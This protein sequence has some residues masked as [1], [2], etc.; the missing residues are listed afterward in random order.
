MPIDP[1]NVIDMRAVVHGI[2]HL[3]WFVLL[4]VA[5]GTGVGLWLVLAEEVRWEARLVVAGIGAAHERAMMR[6]AGL[7]EV[8]DRDVAIYARS[9]PSKTVATDLE[10]TVR[11][12][13]EVIVA[14][15]S[16]QFE[17][18]KAKARV[19]DL[20]PVDFANFVV[21]H[22]AVRPMVLGEPSVR[23]IERPWHWVLVGALSGALV[24]FGALLL[25]LTWRE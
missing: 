18:L 22:M 12:M 14:Q 2:C 21:K 17:A 19:Y 11:E 15:R 24:A 10:K 1:R 6:D 13:V 23:K 9:G 5:I 25:W 16:Q 8:M 7:S 3:W 20:E 4:S